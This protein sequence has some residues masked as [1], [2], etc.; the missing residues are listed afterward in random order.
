[1]R[2]AIYVGAV[3]ILA[4]FFALAAATV[5]IALNAG[6]DAG[7]KPAAENAE[8]GGEGSGEVVEIELEGD[9]GRPEWEVE[10]I[11]ADGLLREVSVD[12]E[13]EEVVGAKTEKPD[14][15]ETRVVAVGAREAEEAAFES[16]LGAD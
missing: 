1:M 5:V 12:A 2:K 9:G 10:V 3:A 7:S 13:S 4:A 6:E 11:G 15:E 16:L 14:D 8:V